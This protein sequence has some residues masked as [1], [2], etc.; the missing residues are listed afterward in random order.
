MMEKEINN[1]NY[2]IRRSFYIGQKIL[3]ILMVPILFLIFV[4]G[5]D[6]L[7]LLPPYNSYNDFYLG[8]AIFCLSL[9]LMMFFWSNKITFRITNQ[10]F[11][12]KSRWSEQTFPVD[13][14]KDV[15][16][17]IDPWHRSVFEILGKYYYIKF[18]IDK[19]KLFASDYKFTDNNYRF[20][21]LIGLSR[22]DAIEVAERTR[23]IILSQS[24]KTTTAFL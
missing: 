8:L 22:D 11:S 5:I 12:Q 13:C 21:K 2:P 23:S 16:L 7:A 1:E 3:I 20:V 15:Q 9:L 18:I 6:P 4:L 10:Q 19:D 24:T 17:P 14:I